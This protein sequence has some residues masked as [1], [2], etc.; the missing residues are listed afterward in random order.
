MD[1]YIT[2]TFTRDGYR[3]CKAGTED[4]NV[5]YKY[6]E[7]G[8]HIALVVDEKM[9]YGQS[10]VLL[11]QMQNYVQEFFYRP[12]GRL[13]DFPEGFPVYHVE[14]LTIIETADIGRV[15]PLCAQCENV[16]LYDT[17]KSQLII[18]ENQPGDFWG[19]RGK[20]EQISET[21][22]RRKMPYI[23]KTPGKDWAYV[24]S[25][26]ATVNVVIYL[27]LSLK[28]ST[29]NAFYMASNGAMYPDFLLY[30]HQWWRLFTAMFLHFGIAHLMNNMVVFC[31]IGPRLEKAMGHVR[32]AITYLAAGIGGSLL[33]FGVMVHTGEYVVSAGASGAI[34]GMVGALLWMVLL[35]RG[36]V[37]G[38]TVKGIVVMLFLSLY[39][40]FAETGVDNWC[41]IGG[42]VTGF[43]VAALLCHKREDKY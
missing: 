34:F 38:L 24:T 31:C 9:I 22:E 7:E 15:R 29:T 40:G 13:A 20:L 26:I 41:H 36:N 10:A 4:L 39:L 28:G 18:Y 35:Y 6:Y 2:D 17:V 33:S 14:L 30:N 3:F 5:F 23:P 27:L 11:Q 42:L 16:W 43:L 25:G 21:K 32:F 37:E 19:I 12:Q 1:R 8:F